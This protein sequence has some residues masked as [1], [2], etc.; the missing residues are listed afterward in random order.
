MANPNKVVGKCKVTIDG[1]L[2][3]TDGETE[4]E[5]GGTTREPVIGDNNAGSFRAIES[6][7]KTTTKLLLKSALSLTALREIDNAT[8]V[9]KTDVGTTYIVRGAYVQDVI[10]FSSSDGKA[11]VV[12]G[13]PA[14]EEVR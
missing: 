7:S 5:L 1:Q 2:L 8:L 11:T 13:G 3:D 14:A 9:N 4:M 12:W 6:A 10:S